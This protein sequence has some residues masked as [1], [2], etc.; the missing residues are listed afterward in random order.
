MGATGESVRL[1]TREG[2][3]P[4][5]SPD[6]LSIAYATEPVSDPY[7]RY[8]VSQLWTV[9]IASGKGVRLT[10][11][12]AVQPAWSPD[13]SRIA[14][15]AN[16]RGQRDLWTVS[17]R[18][19]TPVAVTQ[20]AATDWSP[21]WSPDGQWLYFASDRSGTMN[22]WRVPIDRQTGV[23]GG[24][25]QPITSSLTPVAHVRFGADAQRAVVMAYGTTHELLRTR[26]GATG[27][28]AD[29]VVI[30]SPS[31]GWCS[32]SPSADWLACTS[33]TAQED[34]VLLR[35]DG[36]ETIR[37]TDDIA[38]DRNPTWSP[39]GA[40]IAFMSTRSGQ[41]ELWSVGRD[42][43]DL[44]QM[45]DLQANLY[46]T[47]WSPDGRR[48]LTV[49]TTPGKSGAWIFDAATLAT[50]ENSTFFASPLAPRFAAEFWSPNGRSVAGSILDP[51]GQP[52]QPAV[53]EVATGE[54]RT[55]EVPSPVNR[56]AFG[57]AGWFPNSSRFLFASG[58]GLAAV[59]A[60]TGAWRPF[61]AP[62]DAIR[63][64]LSRDGQTLHTERDILDADIW[65]MEWGR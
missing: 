33:R 19:G 22:I 14:Y 24:D 57:V 18:G 49:S 37:L 36:A 3:D 58:L 39:D 41:W 44:R 7:A 23:P 2:F 25:P 50:Q 30:R 10:E 59:D 46:E 28:N 4:T 20:G 31:L 11:G 61:P 8:S 65:L 17:A 40:R 32:P 9:E 5:W 51:T 52:H 53:W 27:A 6:G 54:I 12:D 42:G 62:E 13:G 29:P 45:T 21:E 1:V 47:V 56:F 38:K 64:R 35:P 48:V 34:I 26:V 43:S 60:D 16:A 63:Y 55:L 15:W